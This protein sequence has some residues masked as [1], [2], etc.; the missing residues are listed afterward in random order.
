MRDL[1]FTFKCDAEERQ[2]VTRLAKR[3]QR[4]ESDTIRWVLKQAD[5]ELQ[6]EPSRSQH[7]QSERSAA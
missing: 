5:Q 2:M 1:T 4:T 3:L 6:A 7:Q